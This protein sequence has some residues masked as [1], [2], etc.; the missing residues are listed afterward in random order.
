VTCID[1]APV[2]RRKPQQ[3]LKL[4]K[5]QNHLGTALCGWNEEGKMWK[6][7]RE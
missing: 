4:C 1:L 5:K 3:I 2:T 7:L 6:V